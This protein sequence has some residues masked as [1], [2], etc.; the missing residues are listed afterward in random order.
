MYSAD[1]YADVT[2]I[3]TP[4][5]GEVVSVVFM[6]E[7]RLDIYGYTDLPDGTPLKVL[8]VH[9]DANNATTSIVSSTVTVLSGSWYF[10]GE[11][12]PYPPAIMQGD[13]KWKVEVFQEVAPGVLDIK[14]T[15]EGTF[16]TAV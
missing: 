4:A 6:N 2:T 15:H 12:H 7:Q 11:D 16:E 13:A 1:C 14:D 10:E 5:D 9:R 3:G 8:I